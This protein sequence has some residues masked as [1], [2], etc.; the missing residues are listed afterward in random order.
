MKLLFLFICC[1]ACLYSQL[2]A[3]ETIS[4]SDGMIYFQ[5]ENSRFYSSSSLDSIHFVAVG[6]RTRTPAQ[7][8]NKKKPHKGGKDMGYVAVLIPNGKT[9][10]PVAEDLFYVRYKGKKRPTRV[11]TVAIVKGPAGTGIDIYITGRGGSDTEGIGFLRH[12]TW[13]NKILTPT[14]TI[15]LEHKQEGIVYTHGYSL[16]TGDIDGDG[17]EES[18]YGRFYGKDINEH[19]SEDFALVRIYKKNA[20]GTIE[21]TALRP[22]DQLRIPIRVNALEVKDINADGKADIIIAG[23]GPAGDRE[24]S[25]FAIWSNDRVTYHVNRKQA[26]PG[27]FRTVMARDLDGDGRDELITGGRINM[28][29]RMLANLQVWKPETHGVTLLAQY[30]WASDA[31]TRLRALAPK[32][33][34]SF[35]AA[36][37]TELLA[38]GKSPRW[39][40]F[41]RSFEFRKNSLWPSEVPFL[42]DNGPETRIRDIRLIDGNRYL[43]C[44]FIMKAEKKSTGFLMIR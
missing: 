32:G 5:V 14:Q 17:K 31:S 35:V 18:V 39:I 1:A 22:F 26:L 36:G 3:T 27:R 43:S 29:S 11:R 38:G 21:E 23:R 41:I 34:S 15:I 8:G 33:T 4:N 12:Y 10:Q 24:Y 9:F 20:A 44:G 16:K 42:L 37:R 2:P 6:Q 25:A 13:K 7:K 40:G 28:G 19:L 30:S